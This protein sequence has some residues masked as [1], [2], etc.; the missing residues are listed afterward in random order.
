MLLAGIRRTIEMSLWQWWTFRESLVGYDRNDGAA[1][2]FGDSAEMVIYI[3][4]SNELQVR[5]NRHLNEPA[6]SCI[7]KNAT[8]YRYEYTTGYL[9]REQELYDE[10]VALYGQPP[11]CNGIRPS[12]R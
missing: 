5:L 3:G 1:Y 11:I 4:S 9:R 2:E 12:G 7:K 6:D 8:K 10:H